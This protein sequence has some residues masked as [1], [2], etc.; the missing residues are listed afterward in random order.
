MPPNIPVVSQ[1]DANIVRLDPAVRNFLRRRVTRQ[2]RR[3]H[4]PQIQLLRQLLGAIRGQ[5]DD[6]VA[7]VEAQVGMA[8]QTAGNVDL[9]GLRGT[10]RQQV[11]E[12]IAA[13]QQSYAQAIPLLTQGIR[14]DQASD[15]Q[16]AREALLTAKADRATDIETTLSSELDEARTQGRQTL[17]EEEDR[18][19]RARHQRQERRQDRRENQRDA[20]RALKDALRRVESLVITGPEDG[21][22]RLPQSEADWRKVEM[23]VETGEGIGSRAAQLAV[24]EARRYVAELVEAGMDRKE[25]RQRLEAGLFPFGI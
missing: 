23:K 11:K 13:R 4:R 15:L 21:A 6:Q 2:V 10:A 5:Y 12:D 3:E 19:R 25:L 22:W 17:E 14:E 9:S 1:D 16:S 24:E 18:R 7:Q 8:Q 20:R